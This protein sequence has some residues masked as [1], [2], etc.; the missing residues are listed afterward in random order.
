MSYTD[1]PDIWIPR[2]RDT[3]E[4]LTTGPVS[5]ELAVAVQRQKLGQVCLDTIN[6]GGSSSWTYPMDEITELAHQILQI[7]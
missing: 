4:A 1:T 6:G 3:G 7:A 2:D 5:L